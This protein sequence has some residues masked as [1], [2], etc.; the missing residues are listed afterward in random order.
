MENEKRYSEEPEVVAEYQAYLAAK[1]QCN[2][3]IN[4]T[5]GEGF[6]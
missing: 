1:T 4:T 6:E 2:D 3:L 5:I